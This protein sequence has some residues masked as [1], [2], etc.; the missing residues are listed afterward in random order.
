MTAFSNACRLI[1]LMALPG[2]AFLSCGDDDDSDGDP[3]LNG[4]PESATEQLLDMIDKQQW[5]REWDNLHPEQQK[6]VSRDKFVSCAKDDDSP[7]IDSVEV[8][9]VDDDEMQIPGTG[10]RAA[11]KA[12]TVHLTL[13]QTLRQ[14]EGETWDTIHLFEVDGRWR[15]VLSNIESFKLGNCPD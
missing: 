12:V 5:G 11:S 3:G 6:F 4:P 8:L 1:P 14:D 7:S 15:W 2:L 10:I 9:D 13:R